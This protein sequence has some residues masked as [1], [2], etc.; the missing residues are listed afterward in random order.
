MGYIADNAR[1]FFHPAAINEMLSTFLPIL[2]GTQLDVSRV[3]FLV[4]YS[5]PTRELDHF[6]ISILSNNVPAVVASP[7]LSSHVVSRLGVH[8]FLHVRRKDAIFSI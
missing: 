7:I 2:D 3:C 6:I 1:K 5:N 8:Q 4:I